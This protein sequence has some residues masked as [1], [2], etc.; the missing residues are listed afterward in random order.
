MKTVDVPVRGKKWRMGALLREGNRLYRVSSGP[1]HYHEDCL[2]MQR[3]STVR[4]LP[5]DWQAA[6]R[7]LAIMDQVEMEGTHTPESRGAYGP[8]A[9]Q[10]APLP[11]VS[12]EGVRWEARRDAESYASYDWIEVYGDV[13]R[14]VR[15]MYDDSPVIT[16]LCDSALAD[17]ARALIATRPSLTRYPAVWVRSL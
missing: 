10:V 8:R 5:P 16:W 13:L 7:L 12:G 1:I 14:C 4:A 2:P 3:V 11:A 9:E 17:E 6:M 15:P